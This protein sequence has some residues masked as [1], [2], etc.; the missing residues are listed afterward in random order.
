MAALFPLAAPSHPGHGLHFPFV[1]CSAHTA[2][3]GGSFGHCFLF[4]RLCLFHALSQ[5]ELKSLI[6]GG[7]SMAHGCYEE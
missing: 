1:F 6:K 7:H 4:F 5:K 2:H 3:L